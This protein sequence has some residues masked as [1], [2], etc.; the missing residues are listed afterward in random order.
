MNQEGSGWPRGGRP[1]LL[2]LEEEREKELSCRKLGEGPSSTEL[3]LS[4]Q[5]PLVTLSWY[6]LQ[7][8]AEDVQSRPGSPAQAHVSGEY[9]KAF[10]SAAS[11]GCNL[12][13]QATLPYS[14]HWPSVYP[15]AANLTASQAETV[16]GTGP[17]FYLNKK[18]AW[19]L[20]PPLFSS[21]GLEH[22]C[23]LTGSHSKG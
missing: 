22:A 12:N 15:S 10:A 5:S 8:L 14:G 18:F 23:S 2:L 9:P 1:W 16:H 20:R 19:W 6:S 21:P 11:L 4:L 7:D 3:Q 13:M 17:N